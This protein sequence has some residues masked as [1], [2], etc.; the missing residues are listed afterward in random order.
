M[1]GCR[2]LPAILI[3][4]ALALQ[5]GQ[6]GGKEKGTSMVEYFGYPDCIALENASARVVLGLHGGRVLEYAWK[7]ENAI[8]L[9]PAHRGWVY[10]PGQPE[11]DPSG[12]RFDVGPELVIP[13]HPDLWLGKWQ[14]EITGPRR[15]R[16]TSPEDRPTGT[17]LI[18]EFELDE[19]SSHLRCTQIIKNVSDRVQERCHWSRTFAKGRGIC[20]VPLS[21]HLNRFPK[22]YIV[23]GPGPIINYAPEDPNIRVR[24]GFVEIVD[25]PIEAWIAVDSYAGWFGY[26]MRSD[27]LFVKR[28]PTYPERMHA[29]L[30]GHTV[31]MWY[32][33]DVLCELEP[34]GPKEILAPGQSSSFTEDWWLLPHP[35]PKAG[36]EVDLAG[37]KKL[38]DSQAR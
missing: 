25:T 28:F 37:V 19:D 17:R 34:F 35:F 24:E 2:I 31:V 36:E 1:K 6:A 14:G 20:L 10:E 30:T 9:D 8:Y 7:G 16:L 13:A 32:Y 4:G 38:V 11:I 21:D 27:L 18:R 15:A 33:K 3:A 23:Y 29:D 12:G 26:L 22:K 5:S